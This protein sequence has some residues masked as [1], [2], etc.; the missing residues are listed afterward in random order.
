M[1]SGPFCCEGPTVEALNDIHKNQVST[2]M[3]G[4]DLFALA[5]DHCQC[6][7]LHRSL[8]LVWLK[9]SARG[10]QG[11][12]TLEFTGFHVGCLFSMFDPHSLFNTQNFFVTRRVLVGEEA[13]LDDEQ[14]TGTSLRSNRG[15]N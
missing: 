10:P 11:W 2:G 9:S 5:G 15:Q 13:H 6:D 8:F 4:S 12:Y 14:I 7:F 3:R 1:L